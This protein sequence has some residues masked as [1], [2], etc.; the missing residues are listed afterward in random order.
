MV[1]KDISKESIESGKILLEELDK[2]EIKVDAAFWFFFSDSS[3]W[4]LVFSLP[5]EIKKGP[6]KAYSV[7]QKVYSKIGNK[8]PGLSINDVVLSNIADPLIKI[9]KVMIHT[10]PEISEI[11]LTQ[12]MINGTFIE[13]AVMYRLL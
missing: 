2:A 8:L 12:N 13:D 5:Q 4:K 9:L 10:G 3:S 7:I 11:R 1:T 6:K